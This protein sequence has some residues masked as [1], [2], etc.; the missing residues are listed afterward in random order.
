MRLNSEENRNILNKVTYLIGSADIAAKL[1]E[2]PALLPFDEAIIE[3]LNDVSRV[4]LKD[5]RS[6]MY[7][8]VV[9]F[10]FWIR[11]ASVMKL[12]GRFET[13]DDALHLGKGVAFHIA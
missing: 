5:P 12:K 13:G 7:S 10:G 8:D 9:T 1:S 4:L 11:K 3:F 6:K 2:V